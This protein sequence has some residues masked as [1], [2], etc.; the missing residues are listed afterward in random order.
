MSATRKNKGT[1]GL[2]SVLVVTLFFANFAFAEQQKD[3]PLPWMA[4]AKTQLSQAA[5][6][7]I[8]PNLR[9]LI[10]APEE[11]LRMKAKVMEV[12]RIETAE[13][14]VG[15]LV[16]SKG[17]R[18]ELEAVGARVGSQ[19]GDIFTVKI[20][21]VRL[22]D[23]AT[24]PN[25]V[26]IAP[27]MR[28]RPTLDASIPES[29]ANLV[30]QGNYGTTPPTYAGYTG[31]GVLVGAIDTGI[32]WTHGDFINDRNGTSRILYIWDQTLIPQGN[33][34]HPGGFSYGVEYT[35]ADINNEIDGSPAGYVRTRDT[36]GHGTHVMGIIAGDGSSMGGGLP[37]YTYV[38]MAPQ[39]DMVVIKSE[40]YDTHILDGVSYAINKADETGKPV[41]LNMSFGGHF[42]AHDGTSL[43]EQGI[44]S[45]IGTG[46]VVVVVSAGNEGTDAAHGEYI[47]AEGTVTTGSSDSTTISVPSYSTNSGSN[48]DFFELN[49]W[50]Q[51]R[52]NVNVKVTTPNGYTWNANTGSDNNN[53]AISTPDGAI[54]ID[55][56]STGI[57][58]NNG[59]RMC[60]ISIWDYYSYYP[61]KTGTWT[62]TVRGN[63]ITEG[64]HYDSWIHYSQLGSSSYAYFTAASGSNKEVISIPGTADK[65]I[66]VA[67]H[68]TKTTWIDYWGTTQTIPDAVLND[69]AYFSSVGPTRD[70]P[71]HITGRQKP[72]ISA[73]G[74]GV[75]SARSTDATWT[76]LSGNRNKDGVHLMLWGTS[77]SAPH[78]TGAVALMLEKDNTLTAQQAKTIL[79][80]SARSDAYTGTVPNY[81]WGYG[82]LDIYAA[83]QQV[84][85]RQ[86]AV[87]LFPSV[88]AGDGVSGNTVLY[89]ATVKN[90]GSM[91]DSYNLTVSGNS[92]PTTIWD[93]AGTSQISNTGNMASGAELGIMIKVQVPAGTLPSRREAAVIR[94]T[95]V[96]NS[97]IFD[98]ATVVTRTPAS[99]PWS[100][101]FPT[102]TLD[103]TKWIFNG[104]PAEVNSSGYSEPSS[105]YSLNLNGNER[106][107]D[108]VQSQAIDLSGKSNVMLSY[109][110]ERT[111]GGNSPETDD[112][113]WV[114]YYNSAGTW[115][116]LRR[117]LGSA[118]D[119]SSY[120]LE[121][122]PLPIDAHHTR[123]KIR[124]R[125]VGTPGPF[126]DWF[127]DDISLTEVIPDTIPW[128]DTFPSTTLNPVKWPVD[129]G[130]AEVN[131]VGLNEPSSPYSLNLNGVDEVQSQP[132]D[133]SG[134]SNVALSYYYEKKGGGDSP[135]S[136]DDLLVDYYNS[137]GT[138]V[139]LK[140]H[141]GSG[142][143][144]TFYALEQVSLPTGAY[145]SGF[146]IRFRTT[147]DAGYDDWF[148]DDVSVATFVPPVITWSPSS[149]SL[150]V[151]PEDTS[152]RILTIGN[153]GQGDLIFNISTSAPA[154]SSSASS[155]LE[156]ARRDY[157]DN[158]F[159]EDIGKGET[160]SRVGAPVFLG[161]GGPDN[162]GHYWKDSDEP[163]GPTFSWVDISTV[164]TRITGISDDTNVGPFNIGFTFPLYGN[165]FTSFRFCTNGFISFTSTSTEYSNDP[166]PNSS[167]YNLVAPFWDDL[168][169][170]SNGSAYYHFDGE[171]LIVEYKDVPHIF[172][173]GPYTFE[174]LLY[175]D[176]RIKFQYLSMG[177]PTNECTVGIQNSDGT[178]GLE[179]A[180]N[181]TYIHDN[182]AV[183]IYS[184]L[185]WLSVKPTSGRVPPGGSLADTLT[186]ITTGLTPDSTYRADL[187]I[188]SNDPAND[189]VRVPVH[190]TVSS[191][192]RGSVHFV[193]TD[194]TGDSYSI[195]V[196]AATLDGSPLQSGDEI[197]VFTPAGLCVGASVWDGTTPLPLTAWIDDSQT[198]EVDGYRVGEQ[199][200]FRIWDSSAGTAD[201]Y[202]ATPTY[203]VGNG[204]FGDGAYAR[205]SRLEAVTSVT[206]M[207]PLARGWSWISLNV[208]PDTLDV[209]V[210]MRSVEHLV[211]MVNGAGQFYIPGVVNTIGN[212]NVL[213]GYKVYVSAN[214][215]LIVQGQQVL[216]WTPIPLEARWNFISYLPTT[217]MNAETALASV[218]PNLAIA[219][220][221][222]GGFYI[223][224]VVNTMGD[225][226]PGEAYK[227]YLNA[228]DTLIYPSGSSL[229]KLAAPSVYMQPS[230]P[231]HF[232]F[233]ERTGD[234]HS[235]LITTVKIDAQA[236]THGDEIGIFTESGVCVGGAVWTGEVPL[237]VAA[238]QDNDRTSEIDGFQPGE[239]MI[240]KLWN[241]GEKREVELVATFHRGDGTFGKGNYASVELEATS[242]PKVYALSQNYPNPFNPE[243]TIKYQL[244]KAEKVSLVIY[245]LL[246]QEVR[247]L[248]DEEKA[249]GYHTI[250]WDGKDS[251]GRPVSTGIYIYRIEA[252]TFVAS[253]KMIIVK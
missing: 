163:G 43:L 99:L 14:E 72:D 98:Q 185:S 247:R 107:G 86:R 119:M 251:L 103:T 35:Q 31:K 253:R 20:P 28:R 158:Y 54:Y 208:R 194:S 133:L 217:P 18:A 39:A 210:V 237:A 244:T 70:D 100:D 203:S 59:D 21:I 211:I 53:T 56:A 136:G 4:K 240:F 49:L 42:G 13:P 140:Q 11:F 196:D 65:V 46:K 134:E 122:I 170:S 230:S 23:L 191:G 63:T 64:G 248:V 15:L 104:G 16:K 58:P 150:S 47:H 232:K 132:I 73:S 182:L 71:G 3:Q 201:D 213:E 37:A 242:L 236:P 164:G 178:D 249:A 189:T 89:A 127:I 181:T 239:K 169:F 118:S 96:A 61:P 77:V 192:P 206:Q 162:F 1:W 115:V 205:I 52:D 41:A 160:D 233:A 171:K 155:N 108:E 111:G 85:Q 184:P 94:A 2:F 220:N 109:Y 135:E 176:G 147:G 139:N 183:L 26:S 153:A 22:G 124:F 8:P 159:A 227:L 250:R 120:I 222:V 10:G 221:D 51:G 81:R 144:M 12:N 92:W 188:A 93:A 45:A 76:N 146:R 105:P 69:L 161:A 243:T 101:N 202:P 216:A 215:T 82:K 142:A 204:T 130:P 7:K 131:T 234:S 199:M 80:S 19:I 138:W 154:T 186:F 87:N 224:G 209:A 44:D 126:D 177:S 180:F 212:I 167:V 219:K 241:S 112:D 141:L 97:A 83:M 149:F 165:N 116:T 17:E 95:S 145:H 55:N 245:N 143:D 200:F 48:N 228:A 129:I 235:V 32:D 62:V 50:Y 246:G 102:T 88:Q 84:Q 40:L 74:F 123:F 197:G 223:P 214:D 173:G 24:N 168:D 238:W 27:S 30:H 121:Q 156:P 79:T 174:I 6:Q 175:P 33:E 5:W 34:N 226:Q 166:I 172:S 60:F 117:Y 66:T 137:S 179:I 106:G 114:D 36:L 193:F 125:N 9:L 190:L 128:M 152:T 157:P 148:V 207:I 75:I 151:A 218:R 57:D 91:S 113:L 195:V 198:P 29:N 67:A 225:M 25:V 187:I 231:S 252:G 38:G 78:I 110:Y 68:S 90:L 229:A